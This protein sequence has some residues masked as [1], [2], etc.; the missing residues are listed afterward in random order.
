MHKELSANTELSHYFRGKNMTH[1]LYDLTALELSHAYR[2][3]E[4]SPVEVTRAVLARIEKWEPKINAM[5]IIDAERALDQAAASETRWRESNPLSH[6][7][8]VPITNRVVA[9]D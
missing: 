1:E 2:A 5:Y 3:K 4:L 6:L 8:G 9:S 7:D